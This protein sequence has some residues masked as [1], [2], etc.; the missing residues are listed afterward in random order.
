MTKDTSAVRPCVFIHTNERQ[1]IGARVGEYAL[2]RNSPNA[3]KFDVRILKT[4]DYPFIRAKEGLPFFRNGVQRVWQYDDLQSFTPLRFLPPEIM[5]YQGR[6][7]VIDPD[8]FAVGDV[9][10]AQDGNG[11]AARVAQLEALITSQTST[12]STLQRQM[13]ALQGQVARL[14]GQAHARYTDGAVVT[15]I[16]TMCRAHVAGSMHASVQS[17]CE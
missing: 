17:T 2:K 14:Q 8:I 4:A 15:N 11:L 12:I 13:N 1:M 6:A 5:G 10:A 9:W 3:E 16:P 7:V